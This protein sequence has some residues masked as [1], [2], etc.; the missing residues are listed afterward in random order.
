MRVMSKYVEIIDPYRRLVAI[1]VPVYQLPLSRIYMSVGVMPSLNSRRHTRI[2]VFSSPP[3][4]LFL[5]PSF[6]SFTL[7]WYFLLLLA[8]NFDRIFID[9]DEGLT[10]DRAQHDRARRI[11]VAWIYSVFLKL[12][13]YP[14]RDPRGFS[15]TNRN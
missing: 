2:W 4:S 10:V 11:S 15:R 1:S 9:E 12:C 3:H 7:E 6:S 8:R 14:R 5:C 13:Y